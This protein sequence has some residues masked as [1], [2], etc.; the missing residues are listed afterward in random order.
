MPVHP[1]IYLRMKPELL[2]FD[3]KGGPIHHNNS[4]GF[5]SVH[6]LESEASSSSIFAFQ[7]AGPFL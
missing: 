7:M 5:T 1:F 4:D 3:D 2:F 6:Y